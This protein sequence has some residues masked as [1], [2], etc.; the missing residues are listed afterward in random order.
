MLSSKFG[1]FLK[2]SRFITCFTWVLC[3]SFLGIPLLRIIPPQTLFEFPCGV[4]VFAGT[5]YID[6]LGGRIGW[7]M[8]LS[9]SGSQCY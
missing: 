4:W 8:I 6:L 2:H 1:A 3:L 9:A 7:G 5:S